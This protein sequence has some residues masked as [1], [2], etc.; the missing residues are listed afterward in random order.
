MLRRR[1]AVANVAPTLTAVNL[2]APSIVEQ[3]SVTVDATFT[4]PG[5]ADTF[6]LTMDWGDG[7]SWST[8]LAAGVRAASASHQYLVAGPFVITVTVKDRNNATNSLTK[9]LDVRARNR[10]PSVSSPTFS[11]A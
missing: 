11:R 10:A 1:A 7:T 3:E 2:S 9:T 5:T 8:D 6:T 4:D